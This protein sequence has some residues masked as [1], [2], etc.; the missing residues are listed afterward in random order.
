MKINKNKL[1]INLLFYLASIVFV[2]I[3]IRV[4]LKNKLSF[5]KLR[6]GLID[7]DDIQKMSKVRNFKMRNDNDNGALT[8][9]K[10]FDPFSEV[11]IEHL[12]HAEKYRNKTDDTDMI[13]ISK[14][15]KSAYK[16]IFLK[17]YKS[18]LDKQKDCIDSNPL[19]KKRKKEFNS[20]LNES[21]FK[22][23]KNENM[24]KYL[25]WFVDMQKKIDTVRS[26]SEKKQLETLKSFIDNTGLPIKMEKDLCRMYIE[27]K[28]SNKSNL[29]ATQKMKDFITNVFDRGEKLFNKI[30]EHDY[31]KNV[32]KD[33]EK[34]L[35]KEKK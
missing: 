12:D 5:P 17:V 7:A 11:V 8:A 23:R 22:E 15:K 34:H 32:N 28:D 18:F 3:I 33:Y 16:D 9:N 31:F 1:G 10:L 20:L 27:D 30:K 14:I 25:E 35:K 6:E 29:Q 24:K 13:V 26:N 2:F 4:F 19:F 21:P